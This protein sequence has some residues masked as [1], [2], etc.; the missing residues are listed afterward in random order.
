MNGTSNITLIGYLSLLRHLSPYE[1]GSIQADISNFVLY[2]CLFSN[3]D[4][5]C[6]SKKSRWE[7]LNLLKSLFSNPKIIDNSCSYLVQLHKTG[8][9]RTRRVD[10][11]VITL[12]DKMKSPT[13][14]VG[15]KNLGCIC[16]MNS[17]MQQL[18]MIPFFRHSIVSCEDPLFTQEES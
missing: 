2:Q 6:K 15:L 10:D 13:G 16:Y 11:W 17:F 12:L 7:A 5:K 4:C 9:W 14:Y 18:Y 8:K 3:D 1:V